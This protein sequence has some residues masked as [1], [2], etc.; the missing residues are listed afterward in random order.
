MKGKDIKNFVTFVR[1]FVIPLVIM[2]VLTILFQKNYRIVKADKTLT[3]PPIK[4][5]KIKSFLD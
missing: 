1:T 5:K 2:P 4:E 3:K